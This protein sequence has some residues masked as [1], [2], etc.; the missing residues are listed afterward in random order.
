MPGQRNIS[1]VI[2]CMATLAVFAL[3]VPAF[4][5]AWVPLK[6][7]GSVSTTYSNMYVRNHVTFDGTRNPNSG[8]I[9]TNMLL[10]S[11]EYGFSDKLALSADLAYIASKY[12]G[13]APHSPI[14]TD[15]YHPTF[16]DA[17]L[18]LRYNVLRKA[19]A[20]TPFIG[21]T[22][23]THDYETRGHSAVGRG[24]HELL[25]GVNVGRQLD[26]IL[27]DSYVHGRYSYA[28]L[29]RVEDL[30][31]NRSNADF[32]VGWFATRLL[33]FRFISAFQKTHGGIITPLNLN[34]GLD[35]H[36]NEFHDRI[37]RSNYIYLGGGVS[38]SVKRSF[39]IHAA[40]LTTVYA[41]N[42]HA[43]GGMLL[44]VSWNF[45]RGLALDHATASISPI[46][47]PTSGRAVY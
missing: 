9:R 40:Y 18:E 11:F 13:K 14:D 23:P 36:K 6:G 37:T 21:T 34:P 7:E 35:A 8:R 33:S 30:K 5:Q 31:L 25:L 44:G 3:A 42:V 16:Q 19:L 2:V 45:S 22:I 27:R 28:I 32:E 47:I 26:R 4:A 24:F 38:F 10:T 29:G 39:G 17:H 12:I 41:R 20:V 43:P 46:Q 1:T 15:S